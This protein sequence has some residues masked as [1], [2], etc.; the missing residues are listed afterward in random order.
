MSEAFN[1]SSQADSPATIAHIQELAAVIGQAPELH[2]KLQQ[3]RGE[4]HVTLHDEFDCVAADLEQL[5]SLLTDA[6]LK[7]SMA[8][9]EMT[10]SSQELQATVQKISA[11]P[12]L[13]MLKRL[14][15]IADGMTT[16]T[17]LTVQ[18]LQFEDMATQLLA[19]VNKRLVILEAFAK[20]MAVLN[21][22]AQGSP[23]MLAPH[24]IDEL[25]RTLQRYRTALAGAN[26]KA[27]Q[28]QS[29]DSGDIELF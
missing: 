17:G 27:V 28:Q 16:T 22:P 19:H 13:P 23:L 3:L 21:P 2:E 11:T 29:L 12:E 20:D 26:H 10:G 8:F 9:R 5:R 7:L 6:A 1:P 4:V 25:T 24:V 18:S 15:E 14:T